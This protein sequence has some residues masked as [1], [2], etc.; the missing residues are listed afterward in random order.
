MHLTP[1]IFFSVVTLLFIAFARW[2]GDQYDDFL[3][4]GLDDEV[5]PMPETLEEYENQII[6]VEWEDGD[7]VHKIAMKR[8]DEE[9]IWDKMSIDKK[10]LQ[11][12]RVAD[13][14]IR[15]TEI[16]GVEYKHNAI[17]KSAAAREM[18]NKVRRVNNEQ[19]ARISLWEKHNK[20][21]K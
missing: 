2:S 20:K 21:S 7:K 11:V 10:R 13:K 8:K 18:A 16:D 5:N 12:K 9:E 17:G 15:T 1:I 14:H 4:L 6:I 3:A 19:G